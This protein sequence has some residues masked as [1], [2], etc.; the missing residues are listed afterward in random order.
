[1]LMCSV[2]VRFLLEYIQVESIKYS[3]LALYSGLFVGFKC[4]ISLNIPQY[5]V[6][7]PYIAVHCAIVCFYNPI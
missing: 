7:S 3:I 5:I 1:M 2:A 6:H 4:E